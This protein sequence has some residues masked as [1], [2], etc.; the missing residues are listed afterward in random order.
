MS[1]RITASPK[2]SALHALITCGGLHLDDA[3]TGGR[4]AQPEVEYAH[5]GENVIIVG[6][7]T[8]PPGCA[9]VDRLL[10][11]ADVAIDSLK[12]G[13]D[14]RLGS[15]RDRPGLDI[16]AQAEFGIM[17]NTGEHTGPKRVGYAA[18]DG[19]AAAVLTEGIHAALLRLERAGIG[20]WARTSLGDTARHAQPATWSECT[21]T[22]SAPRRRGNGQAL[23]A[24]AADLGKVADGHTVVSAQPCRC[25]QKADELQTR[26]GSPLAHYCDL[27]CDPR[28][29]SNATRVAHRDEL[30]TVLGAAMAHLTPGGAPSDSRRRRGSCARQCGR[31]GNPR[32]SSGPDGGNPHRRRPRRAGP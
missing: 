4:D 2:E 11:T 10:E 6:G 12:P 32:R 18:V 28:F 19:V 8:N 27:E 13:S 25:F 30:L 9:L 24:P 5:S 16:A 20:A 26:S 23:A 3:G 31:R 14:R 1:A 15:V 22:G 21:L 7:H 29:R 17:H